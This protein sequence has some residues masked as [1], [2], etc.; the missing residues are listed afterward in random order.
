MLLLVLVIVHLV[1]KG[2]AIGHNMLVSIIRSNLHPTVLYVLASIP[3]G[4]ICN[5]LRYATIGPLRKVY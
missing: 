3:L 2:L 5:S 1:T 4:T